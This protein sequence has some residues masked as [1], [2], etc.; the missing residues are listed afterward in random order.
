MGDLKSTL[1]RLQIELQSHLS[2]KASL[3]GTLAETQARYAS[4]L[5]SLQS[6]VTSLEAQ[7][8]QL[9]AN[10]ASNKQEYDMLLDLKTRL[11]LEIAEYRRLLDGEDDSTKQVVTKVITVVETVVDVKVVESCKTVDVDVDEIE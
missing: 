7:L 1:Q 6:M 11:E 8:S 2:M 3:E 5:V 9:H 10:I 4:Q